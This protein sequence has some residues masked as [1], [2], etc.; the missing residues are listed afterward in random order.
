M[1]SLRQIK[2]WFSAHGFPRTIREVLRCHCRI[3]QSIA[4][5]PLVLPA[6]PVLQLHFGHRLWYQLHSIAQFSIAKAKDNQNSNVPV[7]AQV[8]QASQSRP[9]AN[10]SF[11]ILETWY[12]CF[13]ACRT[14]LA[15]WCAIDLRPAHEVLSFSYFCSAMLKW[16]HM[17]LLEL[18]FG[19]F[20]NLVRDQ[21]QCDGKACTSTLGHAI[22]SWLWIQPQAPFP[23]E[24][25][26]CS[27]SFILRFVNFF[28][29]LRWGQIACRL[30]IGTCLVTCG[31]HCHAQRR[32]PARPS[33]Q[34]LSDRFRGA[35]FTA[36]RQCLSSIL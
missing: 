6:K 12:Q 34:G 17:K 20:Q 1:H 26:Q 21:H 7:L 30:G 28:V 33:S 29:N 19:R 9:Q 24:E 15:G 2:H 27:W 10:A 11:G 4:E 8:I 14:D 18:P 35:L 3:V 36:I 5:R 32:S 23:T 13:E 16:N 25:A 22:I 31:I